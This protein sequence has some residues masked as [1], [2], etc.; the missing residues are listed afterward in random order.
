[1]HL[2][3]LLPFPALSFLFM[4]WSLVVGHCWTRRCGSGR[5]VDTSSGDGSRHRSGRT[6]S[7]YTILVQLK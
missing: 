5:V 4:R 2:N 6:C 3:P 1:M 7:L